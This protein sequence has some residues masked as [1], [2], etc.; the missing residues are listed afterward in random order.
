MPVNNNVDVDWTVAPT[1]THTE[2]RGRKKNET[3]RKNEVD[4]RE[5]ERKKKSQSFDPTPRRR[6]C[7]FNAHTHGCAQCAIDKQRRYS[8]HRQ[9]ERE[10]DEF[11]WGK[12]GREKEREEGIKRR[13][14]EGG[15]TR[16]II[17]D[18][19]E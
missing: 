10:R 4:E 5:K 13:R 12:R 3:K 1:H 18:R 16:T 19:R 8:T 15:T 11:E 9:S 2:S 14:G 6:E 7:V 17:D